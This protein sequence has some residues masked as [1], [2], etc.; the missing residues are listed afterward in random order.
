MWYASYLYWF[1][2]KGLKA[3]ADGETGAA[4]ESRVF[5]RAHETKG[6]I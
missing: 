6:T 2:M 3:E 5:E 1:I 4:S